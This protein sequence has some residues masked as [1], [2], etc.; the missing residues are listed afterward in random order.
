VQF[1]WIKNE[2]SSSAILGSGFSGALSTILCSVLGSRALHTPSSNGTVNRNGPCRTAWHRTTSMLAIGR[3][4]K[5]R[6]VVASLLPTPYIDHLA[7]PLDDRHRQ[8]GECA[9]QRC[10]PADEAGQRA[11]AT[12]QANSSQLVGVAAELAHCV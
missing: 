11:P 7:K 1:V 8:P 5:P 12:A 3:H 10:Q 4:H 9:D 6:L 2:S